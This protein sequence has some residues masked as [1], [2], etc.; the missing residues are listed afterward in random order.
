MFLAVAATKKGK[1]GGKDIEVGK[2]D[3]EWSNVGGSRRTLK[4]SDGKEVSYVTKLRS[5]RNR[6]IPSS[7]FY[8][9]KIEGKD[10]GTVLV[11][12]TDDKNFEVIQILT[13]LLLGSCESLH[14]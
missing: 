8:T 13:L 3:Y 11:E 12:G 2:K 5:G 6:G 9:G 4:I 10:G 1:K 14:H 7:F